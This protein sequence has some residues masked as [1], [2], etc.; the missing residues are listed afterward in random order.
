MT[1]TIPCKIVR[2]AVTDLKASDFLSVDFT[3]RHKEKNA[4]RAWSD[5]STTI[6]VNNTSALG[7]Y[8]SCGFVKR[9][10]KFYSDVPF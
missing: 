2:S 9:A 3:Y 10:Q 8:E 1:R 4:V 5:E 6:S 7:F